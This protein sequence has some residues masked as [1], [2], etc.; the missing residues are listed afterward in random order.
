MSPTIL[1]VVPEL[2]SGGVER[3]AV[4]VGAAIVRAGWRS[5]IA[6]EGGRHHDEASAFGVEIF[7][8]PVE[9]KNP[10]VMGVNVQRLMGLVQKHRVNL[11]H[12]RSRAC[13][14]SAL[15]AARFSG[16]PFVTTYAG[17]YNE[18][19]P[20]KRFYNSVMASGDS[21]IANSFAT[22]EHV[23][24]VHGTPTERLVVIPRGIDL[25]EFNAPEIN[26]AR[27]QI[28]L[29]SWTMQADR[30]VILLP[31][32]L[33]RW[34]GQHVLIE[35]AKLMRARGRDDFMCILAGDE[36]R[37]SYLAEVQ[38]LI[39]QAGLE[40]YVRVVGHCPDM[41]AAYKI[42]DVIV[43]A[44][45]EPEAFGR[46]AVEGQAMGKPVIA[47]AI[48]GSRETI[49]PNETGFLIP[50]NDPSALA[51]ALTHVLD[52]PAHE[53]SA[54]AVRSRRHVESR[55][56]VDA[57]CSATLAV[58]RKLLADRTRGHAAGQALP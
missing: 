38:M 44:S 1:Q 3:T 43:S 36:Q 6:T 58:Y 37:E 56:S 25:K 29:N 27:V 26:P 54:M 48:G 8:M 18:G 45:I 49:L 46:V 41:A 20:G 9:S 57:M 33:T 31:G 13:A 24:R 52:M 22:G 21:V 12:A 55:Y 23:T 50:P 10:F 16:I 28:V 32:R 7:R 15:G 51:D 5:L 19:F 35:A 39:T 14:W 34:K 2:D 30:R 53:L 17:I 4:D 40:N 42:A 11:I 47:T